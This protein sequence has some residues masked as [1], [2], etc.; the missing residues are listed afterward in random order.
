MKAIIVGGTGLAGQAVHRRLLS[1]GIET[2]T[3]ARKNADHC[4]DLLDRSKFIAV[5]DQQ[6]PDLIINCAGQI[7]LK[8]CS[9]KLADS[10]HLNTIIVGDMSAWCVE[11]GSALIQIST[12]HFFHGGPPIKHSEED[13]VSLRND[14]ARQKFAAEHLARAGKSLVIR[15]SMVGFRNWGS[16][17]FAEWAI[18]YIEKRRPMNLWE[19]AWTS[20]IDSN[21]LAIAVEQ[22]ID[23]R[24][25][26]KTL[27]IGSSDIFSKA[28]FIRELSLQLGIPLN[29]PV[30]TSIHEDTDVPRA[31]NLGL[32]VSRAENLLGIKLPTLSEVVSNLLKQR[33]INE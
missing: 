31:S 13:P 6:K 18:S 2:I 32:D 24:I 17:T 16:P 22:L 4:V 15:T 21:S 33:R 7:D 20:L 19:D 14:Y 28:D 27:N 30:S 8:Q 12:D 26:N 10:W 3:L 9:Q 29:Q 5:L 23:Q 11:N 1:S 25:I